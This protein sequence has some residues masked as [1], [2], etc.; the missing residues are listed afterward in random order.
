MEFWFVKVVRRNRSTK[1]NLLEK[2]MTMVSTIKLNVPIITGS[3]QDYL[4]GK[5][6]AKE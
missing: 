2:Q 1:F 4:Y 6:I 5:K 3:S